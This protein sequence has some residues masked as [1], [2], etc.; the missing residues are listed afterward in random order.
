MCSDLSGSGR[1]RT[2]L[3]PAVVGRALARVRDAAAEPQRVT[4]GAGARLAGS[5]NH[6]AARLSSPGFERLVEDHDKISLARTLRPRQGD[7][8]VAF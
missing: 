2:Y 6:R 5:A 7:L 8:F 1:P 4:Q 3:A